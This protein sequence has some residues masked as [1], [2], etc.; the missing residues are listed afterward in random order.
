[1]LSNWV[2]LS[3]VEEEVK[4]RIGKDIKDDKIKQAFFKM[5]P[6]KAHGPDDYHAGFYQNYWKV[7]EKSMCVW[8]CLIYVG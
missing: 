2:L 5:N 1:M 7:V 6:W 3:F 4:E 8:L